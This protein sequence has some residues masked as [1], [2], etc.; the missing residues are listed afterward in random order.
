MKIQTMNIG[1]KV[2]LVLSIVFLVSILIS[3]ITLSKL[4]TQKAEG[5]VASKAEILME[6]VNSI[7]NY[8][9][10]RVSPILQPKLDT[11]TKF[12][13][14]SIP[15]FATK[16]VFQVFRQQKEYANYI[17][18]DATINPLNL[19]DKANSFESSIVDRFRKD[20]KLPSIS[21]FTTLSGQKLFYTARP[22]VV[23]EQSCLRCHSQ[24]ELAPKSLLA[25]YGSDHG[26]GWKLKEVVATQIVYV[27]AADIFASA[28]QAWILQMGILIVIFA[29]ILFLINFLLKKLVVQR[30]KRIAKVAEQVSTGDMNADFVIKSKD[31]IGGLAVAFNRMKRSLE[32]AFNLLDHQEPTNLR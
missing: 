2:S 27:P 28:N 26:F 19:E 16:E 17:Y 6:M 10:D 5:E 31:E 30:I 24:P 13:P 32:I 23:E 1:T 25:T 22:F 9:N 3:G 21:D 14:E 15:T 20:P 12:I 7:R 8:T 11:Q 18:K 4:L 29:G